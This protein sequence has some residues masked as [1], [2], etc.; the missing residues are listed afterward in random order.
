MDQ[1]VSLHVVT[2]SWDL[3]FYLQTNLAYKL[4]LCLPAGTLLI[5]NCTFPSCRSEMEQASMKAWAI[6][7]RQASIWSVFSMSNTN[8]GFF[9]IFTQKRRGKLE[10]E[11]SD[12]MS[13][14]FWGQAT[15]SR[16]H[17]HTEHTLRK[18]PLL[19]A[20]VPTLQPSLGLSQAGWCWQGKYWNNISRRKKK[21]ITQAS[22][23]SLYKSPENK[24]KE[25]GDSRYL[26]QIRIFTVYSRSLG[27]T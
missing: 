16:T 13:A 24:S 12:I 20:L 15:Y 7:D 26:K 2:H 19:T 22:W 1:M 8:W 6:T 10:E 17:T 9:R 27:S 3:L 21:K 11:I 25:K 5:E 14:V 18:D 4:D 23:K